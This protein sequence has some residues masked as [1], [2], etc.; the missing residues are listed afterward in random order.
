M[1]AGKAGAYPSEALHPFSLEAGIVIH[2]ISIHY[3]A[4]DFK[5]NTD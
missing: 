3:R 1:F 5:Y 4:L 2:V